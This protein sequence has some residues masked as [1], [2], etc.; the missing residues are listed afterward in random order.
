MISRY[1]V[2]TSTFSWRAAI[3]SAISR[4]RTSLPLSASDQ[5][6]SPSQCEGWLQICLKRVR[7][8]STSPRRSMPSLRSSRS[9]SS[10][11]ERS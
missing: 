6:P 7:K 8:A 5:P 9:A 4:S 3:V 10:R 11:T 1:C 2:K